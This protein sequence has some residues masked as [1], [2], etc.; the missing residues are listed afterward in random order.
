[1][2]YLYVAVAGGSDSLDVFLFIGNL[3]AVSC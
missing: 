2:L 1:M 3:F